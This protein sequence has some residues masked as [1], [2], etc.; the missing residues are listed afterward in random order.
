MY[1]Y[2]MRLSEIFWIQY[3]VTPLQ[4]TLEAEAHLVGR[5]I[6]LEQIFNKASL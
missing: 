4:T 5:Q 3:K 6:L 2:K 1:I